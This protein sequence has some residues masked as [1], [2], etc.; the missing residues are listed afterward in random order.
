MERPTCAK[1]TILINSMEIS[2][3][4]FWLSM[5]TIMIRIP[6][7]LISTNNSQDYGHEGW[8]LDE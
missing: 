7:A 2:M 8:I 6:H 3:N 1:F 4:K 5:L